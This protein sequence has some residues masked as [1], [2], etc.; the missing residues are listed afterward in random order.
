MRHVCLG[1]LGI[2]VAAAPAAAGPIGLTNGS[3]ENGTTGWTVSIPTGLSEVHPGPQPAG[4]IDILNSYSTPWYLPPVQTLSPTDGSAF[5]L[6]GSQEAGAFF[7][8]GIQGPFDIELTQTISLAAG[9]RLSGDAFF[10]NGDYVAQE[11]A[12][13]RIFDASGTLV[14]TP[15]FDTSGADDNNTRDGYPLSATTYQTASDWIQWSWQAGTGGEYTIAL[16]VTTIGDNYWASYAGFDGV[17]PEPTSGSLLFLGGLF[18]AYRRSRARR[19]HVSPASSGSTAIRSFDSDTD[20]DH[21]P[22]KA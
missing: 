19:Q 17:T 4:T 7:G 9:E 8:Y 16:G 12:W 2:L 11:Q 3:F 10:Y 18:A 15:W 13:V 5:A 22:R 20:G 14:A 6:I 1:V 21:A